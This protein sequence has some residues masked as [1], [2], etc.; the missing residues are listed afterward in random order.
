VSQIAEAASVLLAREPG[1]PELFLVRRA[2]HLR[3]FGGFWAF[4]GGKVCPADADVP[5]T[6]GAA[7]PVLLLRRA[8]AARE[9][10][11]ETGV[12][13]ARQAD[14]SFLTASP[15]LEQYRR[16]M[17][18]GRLS[19]AA[20]LSQ[21]GAAVRADDLAVIGDI[22]TPDFVPLRFDTTFF[23]AHLPPGQRAEVWPGELAEGH[24]A[25]AGS[26]LMCWTRGEC[27]VS[28][29][30][31][32]AL[33]AIR[34]HAAD[35]APTRLGPLLATIAAGAIHPIF[36]FPEVQLLPLRTLALA[37]GAHTN[38]YLLGR[39]PAYLLDPGPH[40]PAEQQRLFDAVD[41]QQR[42]GRRLAAVVLTHHHPDHVGAVTVCAARYGVPVW[43]HP[44]TA[45]KLCGRIAVTREIHEGERLDLGTCPDGRGP[46]HLEA[47]H[48]PGH[49]PGHLAF[50][51]A[52]YR[53]LFVGDMV[54]TLS[55]VVIAPPEGDLA[56]YLRSLH[57][58][59]GYDCR[60]LLPSH[61]SASAQPAETIDA[62]LRH[63]A[64]RE[65]Q[66]LTA[67]AGPARPITELA[68]ELYGDLPADLMR[69]AQLQIQAGLEKLACEG[70][71][72]KL[73]EGPA[74][75]WHLLKTDR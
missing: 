26:L 33:E 59:R 2:D 57:K 45:A 12:L 7:S 1:S 58:L 22:I 43:A 31:V 4:P 49:A 20:I 44:L 75:T 73:G 21:L 5:V 41:E 71:A 70:R 60:L 23:V 3:F 17:I 55:S 32:M 19:F 15:A 34:D 65:E 68:P 50:Y 39:D 54:S 29:P 40:E 69:L 47:V 52:R 8:T 13:L 25:T 35:E 56:E 63:R 42:A 14:G 37:P 38:A 9:L 27:L 30:T 11:E 66:L 67:L 72:T 64:R 16:E 62:C 36:F 10:F 6:A 61:G 24:W 51:E 48:T 28:P 18:A 74:A 46:W 53:L